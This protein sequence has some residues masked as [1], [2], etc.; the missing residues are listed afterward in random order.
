MARV[1]GFVARI[2]STHFRAS[3]GRRHVRRP[4]RVTA[5]GTHP[6]CRSPLPAPATGAPEERPSGPCVRRGRPRVEVKFLQLPTDRSVPSLPSLKV[7]YPPSPLATT[8]G[9]RALH[10]GAVLGFQALRPAVA[11]TAADPSQR[12]APG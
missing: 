1:P 6:T 7:A 9:A 4:G 3:R 2:P 5:D 12:H 8:N 10:A 11:R